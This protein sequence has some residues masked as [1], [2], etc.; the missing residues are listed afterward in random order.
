MSKNNVKTNWATAT[1][2]PYEALSGLLSC[3]NARKNAWIELRK[4]GDQEIPIKKRNPLLEDPFNW[5]M[6]YGIC[7]NEDEFKNRNYFNKT[8]KDLTRNWTYCFGQPDAIEAYKTSRKV[9]ADLFNGGIGCP[10]QITDANAYRKSIGDPYDY[11][12]FMTYWKPLPEIP[13]QIIDETV[14]KVFTICYNEEL[15]DPIKAIRTAGEFLLEISK[16][17]EE[18]NESI[19]FIRT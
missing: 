6:S 12:Y 7:R 2:N 5:T 10:V 18:K 17:M 16:Q 9:S 19:S 1:K 3:I 11:S 13:Y 15:V 4:N 8:E 14:G